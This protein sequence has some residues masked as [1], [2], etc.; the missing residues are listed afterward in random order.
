M[1]DIDLLPYEI[2]HLVSSM[3]EIRITAKGLRHLH[4]TAFLGIL[5]KHVLP[6][7][8]DKRRI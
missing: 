6:L 2:P 8:R 1:L 4:C 3:N 5:Y 7:I